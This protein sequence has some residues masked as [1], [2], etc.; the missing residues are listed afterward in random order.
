MLTDYAFGDPAAIRWSLA[1]ACGSLL[2]AAVVVIASGLRHV[3]AALAA[4][5]RR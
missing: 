3:G 4:S 2:L 1:I 5:E